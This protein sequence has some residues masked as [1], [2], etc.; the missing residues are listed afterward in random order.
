VKK[1]LIFDRASESTTTTISCPN[2]INIHVAEILSS[3]AF[4]VLYVSKFEVSRSNS[5]RGIS[6]CP[7]F[8]YLHV[9]LCWKKNCGWPVPLLD[10]S[11][12]FVQTRFRNPSTVRSGT[13]LAYRVIQTNIQEMISF[14]RI[15]VNKEI[16]NLK[17]S[18][19]LK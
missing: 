14:T 1:N 18:A 4:A 10:G 12:N 11:I 9:A 19:V 5:V 17:I 8:L 15:L 6:E 7:L 16:Q 2:K 3:N 13:T